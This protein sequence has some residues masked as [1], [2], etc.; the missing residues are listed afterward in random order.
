MAEHR[1]FHSSNVRDL[2]ETQP[3]GSQIMKEI[4]PEH[5]K[6]SGSVAFDPEREVLVVQASREVHDE[7]KQWLQVKRAALKS[8]QDAWKTIG[9]AKKVLK[10]LEPEGL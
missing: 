10:G 2:G 3:V 5:W 4:A 1:G 8:I 9:D 7:I 6:H